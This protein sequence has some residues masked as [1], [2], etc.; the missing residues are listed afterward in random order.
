MEAYKIVKPVIHGLIWLVGVT[1]LC[2]GIMFMAIV[3]CWPITG[4]MMITDLNI[5]WEYAWHVY[6]ILYIPWLYMIGKSG[7]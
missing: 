6:F 7:E 3:I 1:G 4:A 2:F 5:T